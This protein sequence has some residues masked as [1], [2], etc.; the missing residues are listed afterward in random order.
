MTRTAGA[1]IGCQRPSRF[2]GLG[3]PKIY[4]EAED[5]LVALMLVALKLL[6]MPA[7]RSLDGAVSWERP[8]AVLLNRSPPSPRLF[9]FSSPHRSPIPWFRRFW[10]PGRGQ[11][12]PIAHFSCQGTRREK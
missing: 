9:L 6:A 1:P 10:A 8:A 11:D 4:H 7:Y 5:T 3:C 2:W 12:R